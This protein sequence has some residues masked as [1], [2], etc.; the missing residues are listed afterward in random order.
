MTDLFSKLQII[1]FIVKFCVIGSE[2]DT[3]IALC[4]LVVLFTTSFC[5]TLYLI[6]M[7]PI[8]V[9]IAWMRGTSNAKGIIRHYLAHMMLQILLVWI[10]QA[11]LATTLAINTGYIGKLESN[12]E[13]KTIIPF[14]VLSIIMASVAGSLF[15]QLVHFL[16]LNIRLRVQMRD[17]CV[18][19]SE[20]EDIDLSNIDQSV[21][22]LRLDESKLDNTTKKIKVKYPLYLVVLCDLDQKTWQY[23]QACS[24]R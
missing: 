13:Q 8:R 19:Q 16:C 17:W 21:S 3:V 1:I 15:L 22:Q 12:H 4:P 18:S 23:I 20:Y 6:I 14:K 9:L 24:E 10:P 11:V 2:I 7:I 5:Y